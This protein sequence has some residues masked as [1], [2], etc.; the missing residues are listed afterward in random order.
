MIMDRSGDLILTSYGAALRSSLSSLEVASAHAWGSDQAGAYC[1]SITKIPPPLPHV[2][3]T[4]QYSETEMR[5]FIQDVPPPSFYA[6]RSS[7]GLRWEAFPSVRSVM[8]YTC[9]NHWK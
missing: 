6:L 3:T 4:S 1:S 5:R 7:P 2:C 8:V 9:A